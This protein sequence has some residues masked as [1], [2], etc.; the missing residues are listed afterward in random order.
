MWYCNGEVYEGEWKSD[1]RCGYGIL[2]DST[3]EIY[4]GDWEGDL[5]NG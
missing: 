5:Y 4:N 2:R 3:G 1:K